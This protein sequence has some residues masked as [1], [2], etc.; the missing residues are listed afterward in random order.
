MS[1]GAKEKARE[2]RGE[3]PYKNGLCHSSNVY[4]QPVYTGPPSDSN[5]WVKVT[6]KKEEFTKEFIKG[7]LSNGMHGTWEYLK[8]VKEAKK[9]ADL[10]LK[11]LDSE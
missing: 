1:D 10:A 4:Q 2:S 7:F 6:T 9:L 3:G 5:L 11:E 8:I